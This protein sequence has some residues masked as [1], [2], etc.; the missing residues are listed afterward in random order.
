MKQGTC[1]NFTPKGKKFFL[2][3]VTFTMRNGLAVGVHNM[4]Q[5]VKELNQ[6]F[7]I[8][9]RSFNCNRRISEH[10]ADVQK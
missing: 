1:F 5:T 7:A 3:Q 10:I 8:V 4:K 9:Y 6:Q 2:W